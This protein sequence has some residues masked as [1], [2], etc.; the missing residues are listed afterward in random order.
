MVGIADC[1]AT[2][3]TELSEINEVLFKSALGDIRLLDCVGD[4][5]VEKL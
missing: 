3:C 5:S 2:G 1:T 4:I